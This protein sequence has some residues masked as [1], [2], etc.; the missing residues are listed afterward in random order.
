VHF[1]ADLLK[2]VPDVARNQAC[3]CADCVAASKDEFDDKTH[4]KA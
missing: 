4:P 2:Q 1:S 3:I